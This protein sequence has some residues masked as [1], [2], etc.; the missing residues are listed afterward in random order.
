MAQQ[1]TVDDSGTDDLQSAFEYENIDLYRLDEQNY[2]TKYQQPYRV[3]FFQFLNFIQQLNQTKFPDGLYLPDS[4][5]YLSPSENRTLHIGNT[6]YSQKSVY[7]LITNGLRSLR[8]RSIDARA[9]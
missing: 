1:R 3:A 2:V 7:F 4:L 5:I 6:T 9:F 8:T